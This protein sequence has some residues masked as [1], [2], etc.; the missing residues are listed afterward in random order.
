ML[1]LNK[2]IFLF[3]STLITF[4][5]FSQTKEELKEQ[6]STLEKEI[7][8]TTNLLNKIG[9]NKR[10]SLDY[11]LVLNKQISN[12]ELLL[13]TLSIEIN[14][15]NKKIRKIELT[16]SETQQSIVDEQQELVTLKK[17]YAKMIY[18]CFK[19]KGNRNNLIFII[20]SKDFNQAYKRIVYLKQY[21]YFRKNQVNKINESQK[22]LNIKE[23]LLINK[24]NQLILESDSKMN[25]INKKTEELNSIGD[26][27]QEKQTL[28]NVKGRSSRHRREPYTT[29]ETINA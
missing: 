8:Y 3:L 9:E 26:S 7:N 25:L 13:K 16:I 18:A 14:L 29:T 19:E 22:K 27:R 2:Y 6:K 28:V 17:E 10:E 4:S 24:N 23:N 5:V 1:R 21:A 15:L 11:L 20:S 12:K